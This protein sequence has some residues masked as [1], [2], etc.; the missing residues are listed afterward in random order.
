MAHVSRQF[1]S[2]ASRLR[3]FCPVD[4]TGGGR[5]LSDHSVNLGEQVLRSRDLGHQVEPDTGVGPGEVGGASPDRIC[6]QRR[7]ENLPR[8]FCLSEFLSRRILAR[9]AARNARGHAEY[10]PGRPFRR[11]PVPCLNFP[12][13]AS[14][15][16]NYFPCYFHN[17]QEG[18]SLLATNCG[19]IIWNDCSFPAE[20]SAARHRL[21]CFSPENREDQGKVRL[22]RDLDAEDDGVKKAR[23]AARPGFAFAVEL[24]VQRNDRAAH[25]P[26]VAGPKAGRVNSG[27]RRRRVDPFSSRKPRRSRDGISR[28]PPRLSPGRCA[29]SKA[30]PRRP[31]TSRRRTARP[32]PAGRTRRRYSASAS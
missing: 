31:K 30:R 25:R 15:Q 11:F 12:V 20:T 6:P 21:P 8:C 19:A 7:S 23:P 29:S 22:I 2:N 10:R 13:P 14:E 16:G 18:I 32:A 5:N 28:R 3:P 17:A 26:P 24:S 9:R 27:R 1:E 4:A